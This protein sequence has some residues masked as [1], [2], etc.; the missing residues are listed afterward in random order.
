LAQ[1]PFPAALAAL[2]IPPL[3]LGIVEA[4]AMAKFQARDVL[5]ASVLLVL[6][7]SGLHQTNSITSHLTSGDA[8][9]HVF[10]F[11]YDTPSLAEQR[12]LTERFL[13]ED[14]ALYERGKQRFWAETAALERA[15][16]ASFG[17]DA[18]LCD[19]PLSDSPGQKHPHLA[20]TALNSSQEAKFYD[21]RR[22][23]SVARAVVAIDANG[24]DQAQ[25]ELEQIDIELAEIGSESGDLLIQ[26]PRAATVPSGHALPFLMHMHI[27]KTG[28]H[29]VHDW[30]VQNA[31]LLHGYEFCATSFTRSSPTTSPW[32]QE[33]I[34]AFMTEY[35]DGFLAARNNS[36][37]PCNLWSYEFG[38]LARTGTAS[39]MHDLLNTMLG[40]GLDVRLTTTLRE[41]MSELLSQYHHGARTG[42][43]GGD[44]YKD[45]TNPVFAE[46]NSNGGQCEDHNSY[47]VENFQTHFFAR[48]EKIA[49]DVVDRLFHVGLKEHL[50]ASMC[51]LSYQLRRFDFANCICQRT[52]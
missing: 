37:L 46:L 3:P 21:D 29:A 19:S 26:Q 34:D 33:H 1:E 9:R 47:Q 28:G 35:E 30:L 39:R 11:E 5:L 7:A 14:L 38:L 12:L 4:S 50:D 44:K 36:Q 32:G 22:W 2:P 41:P 17:G 25:D 52:A 48:S 20:H 8:P 40:H 18:V 45:A 16:Q 42:R 23:R 6:P 43:C 24:E 13:G 10:D 51:L 27:A 49:A 15:L 31:D